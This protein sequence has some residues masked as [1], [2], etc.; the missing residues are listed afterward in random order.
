[1]RV[2][3][4]ALSNFVHGDITAAEGRLVRHRD[5]SL[6]DSGLAGDL[7]RANLVRIRLSPVASKM[8]GKAPAAGVDQPSSSSPVAQAS[9]QTTLHTSKPGGIRSRRT[10]T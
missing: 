7:E 3:A 2:E 4:I 1:M 5:G 10:G 9:Q 6:L 8:A